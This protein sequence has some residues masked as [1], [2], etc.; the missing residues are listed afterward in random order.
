MQKLFNYAYRVF[1]TQDV[2][3][4]ADGFGAAGEAGGLCDDVL[5][6]R[7]LQINQAALYPACINDVEALEA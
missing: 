6:L 4:Q 5:S 1:P 2:D 3:R 7:V